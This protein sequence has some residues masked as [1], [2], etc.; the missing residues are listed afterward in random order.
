M[1]VTILEEAFLFHTGK[2]ASSEMSSTV[3]NIWICFIAQIHAYVPI[4]ANLVNQLK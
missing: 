2:N 1:S 4:N 3:T